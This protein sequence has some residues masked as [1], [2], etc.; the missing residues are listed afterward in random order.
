MVEAQ[1]Q[2]QKLQ[3]A[4]L[5]VTH[6]D[7]HKHT[8][9]L[10]SVLRALLHI[11]E[12]CGVLPLR[13]PF[14]PRWSAERSLAPWLRR[15]QLRATERWCVPFK[16]QASNRDYQ[17]LLPAGTLGMAATGTLS[18]PVLRD[19]LRAMLRNG[20][21]QTWELC[22]HAGHVDDALRLKNT[23][24]IASRAAEYLALLE[25][26]P[27]IMRTAEGLELIHYGNLGIAGLQRASGHF[28]PYNGFEKVL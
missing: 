15:L 5:D 1:A 12:R 18:I 23:R 13:M 10:P 6:L 17:E 26:L 25:V 8:H 7:T 16:E 14:E 28:A 24:L 4:G 20:G 3:R 21:D 2:I 27:E 11:G 22:C 9:I 19:T